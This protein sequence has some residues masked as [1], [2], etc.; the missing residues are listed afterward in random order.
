MI[1]TCPMHPEVRQTTPGSCPECGMALE[2]TTGDT[3]ELRPMSR[4]MWVAVL[5]G[6]PLLLATMVGMVPG[7]PLVG[8]FRSALPSGFGHW[9]AL[10]IATPVCTW[11]A[12]PF[13][14][15]AVASI[16]RMR[17]NMFTLIGIGVSI[18]YLYSAVAV[19]APE[20]FPSAFRNSG[21]QVQIYLESAVA[22]TA[23]VLLGQVLELRARART[24]EA[25]RG[26]LDLSPKTARVVGPDGNEWEKPLE[27][28]QV[29][30]MLRVRPGE[31][32]PVDGVLMSGKGVVDESMISGEPLPVDKAPGD[33]VIGATINRNNSFVMRA[34]RVGS[35]TLLAR[36]VAMVS[37][38]Q[39]SRAP[40]QRSVDRVA[41][42]F[43]P[44]VLLIAATTFVVWALFGPDPRL[45]RALINTVAVLIIACPCALGLATPMAIMVASG[46]GARAGLLFRDARALEVMRK[47]DTLL[48][49]KTGTL[50][51][52]KPRVQFIET[53]NDFEEAELIEAV[54]AVE[55]SSEHPLAG[56][57]LE[58]AE[59]RGL[60]VVAAESFESH[61]GR[62][63]S[64]M[65]GNRN[66]VVGNR[67]LMEQFSIPIA[68]EQLTQLQRHSQKYSTIM[69]AL[70]GKLAG[71]I[72]IADELKPGSK[73]AVEQLRQMRIRVIM[74]TGDSG[75]TAHAIADELGIDEVRAELLPDQKLAALQEI[76]DAGH[77]VAMAGDGINDAPTLAAAHI[78]LAMGA[79]SDAAIDT[80]DITLIKNDI[81]GILRARS[82]SM[83]TVRIIH[84]NLFW[85]FA[86]NVVGISIAAGALYPLFGIVLSP[87][88]AAAAMAFSSVS[89]ITNSLR[90]RRRGNVK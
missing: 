15:R 11:C 38:A 54:A 16:R 88:F 65:T 30:D 78:G 12:W 66:V 8:L 28:I 83:A 52:G 37:D 3:G 33:S 73:P 14:Q 68:E 59:Q 84:Q 20:L 25:I 32:I 71:S 22:I 80:A 19:L 18:T 57:I 24:G 51:E 21:G 58:A 10:I 2:S 72:G 87:I 31:R 1:Y 89:V 82:L 86:Y 56:A 44:V 53:L 42:W 29:G 69:V 75:A 6:A 9:S 62:G 47:V 50:T 46:S 13:Y 77:I 67:T 45:A 23:L 76:R 90:L 39:R 26:L 60:K 7:F 61:I 40:I 17:L 27:A 81:G 43:V 5:L 35:E 34:E 63:I 49:D 70:D 48:V 36:I 85:A 55:L 79:G 64:G 41:A 74:L 4:R